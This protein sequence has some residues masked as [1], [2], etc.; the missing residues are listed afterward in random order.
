MILRALLLAAAALVCLPAEPGLA[1]DAAKAGLPQFDLSRFPSQIFWL[2]VTFA[3]LYLIM[4]K[5]ALPRIG[6]VLEARADRIGNDLD[7]A[8]ALKAEA[9]QTRAAYEK[10]LAESRARAQEV[11]RTAE[12]ALAKETAERQAALN[13]ELTT[14]IRDAETRIAGARN[15]AMAN[16]AGVAAETAAL[17]VERVAGLK[18][19]PA[20][21]ARAAQAALAR[22]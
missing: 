18:V 5:V 8:S 21:A 22:A 15:A 17:A 14:R 13:G 1:A 20:E 16:L 7:R 11:G 6:E 19:D 9:D 10:A 12:T 3:V 2:G 4:S